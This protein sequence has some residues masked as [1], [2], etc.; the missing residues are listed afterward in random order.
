MHAAIGER[1]H[2]QPAAGMGE[3]PMTATRLRAFEDGDVGRVADEPQVAL[4][5]GTTPTLRATAVFPGEDSAW[6]LVQGHSSLGVPNADSSGM[7]LPA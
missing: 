7:D 1:R 4:P 6:R 3:A 5:D 2:A